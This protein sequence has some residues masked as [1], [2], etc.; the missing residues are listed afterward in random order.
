MKTPNPL[1]LK[2]VW[3]IL[4]LL[5][6]VMINFPFIHIFN[7][8]VRF[9]GYPLLFLYFMAG[10]PVSILVVYFFSRNMKDDAAGGDDE[11]EKGG[12]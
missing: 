4:F 7:K 10:W 8:D 6:I 3:L 2:E 11:R 5:G 12:P 1:H 9:F